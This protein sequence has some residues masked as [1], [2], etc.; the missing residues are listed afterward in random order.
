MKRCTQ[1]IRIKSMELSEVIEKAV[2]DRA[3]ALK[4][5]PPDFFAYTACFLDFDG[6][7]VSKT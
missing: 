7:R 1:I 4:P 6:G 3:Q 5:L 2:R